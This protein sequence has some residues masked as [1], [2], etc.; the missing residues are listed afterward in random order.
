MFGIL[1]LVFGSNSPE[2]CKQGFFF[3][4][5]FYLRLEMRMQQLNK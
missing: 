4:G 1:N 2:Q 3:L 5:T